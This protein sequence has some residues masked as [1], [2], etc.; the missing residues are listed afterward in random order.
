MQ[1][2]TTAIVAIILILATMLAGCKDGDAAGKNSSQEKGVVQVPGLKIKDLTVGNGRAAA[3]GD[4]VT[5]HYTGWVLT[6]G[7]KAAEPFD[8]SVPRGAPATFPIGAGR[9]IKG[10]DEGI[11]GMQVGG[12]R[13]LIIEPAMGYGERDTPKIPANSTLI[14]EVEMV[15]IPEV[16]MNDTK[17]G[18]GP[19]AESGDVVQVHYTGWLLKDGQKASEPF[20][21]SVP[22][23]DPFEFQLGAGQVIPGWDIGVKGMKVGGKRT[24]TIPPELGYGDRDLGVIPPNSTLTFDVELLGIQGKAAQ[25]AE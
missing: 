22:R 4:F 11:P 7:Q 15:A 20:D 25:P 13:E 2:T 24:L 23:G 19:A 14:F 6:D 16:Q 1:R 5:V 21:S 8:S 10:W 18:S 9:L 12:K 17:T 3:K